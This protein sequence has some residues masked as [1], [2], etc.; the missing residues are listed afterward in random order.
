MINDINIYKIV[1]SNKLPFGRQD[2]TYF[3][4]YKNDKKIRPLCKFFPKVS[5]YRIDFNEIECVYFMVKEEKVS[6][7]Y[8]EIWEKISN[9][10][11][12]LIVNLY[13]VQNI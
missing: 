2:F 10:I 6:D 1:V 3:D 12:K 11:K 7:K 8:I 9:I 5:A 4:G 13:I